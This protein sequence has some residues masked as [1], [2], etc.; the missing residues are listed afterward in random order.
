MPGPKLLRLP[1]VAATAWDPRIRWPVA[2]S[3]TAQTF[4]ARGG[5]DAGA[6]GGVNCL[7]PRIWSPGLLLVALD[8]RWLV[9][10]TAMST[11]TIV[12]T[13]NN[14]RGFVSRSDP[15]ND[16]AMVGPLSPPWSD[17]TT[18]GGARV[19]AATRVV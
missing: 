3:T 15:A 19:W 8:A 4:L 11:T 7:G 2:P 16:V 13:R 17:S 1:P 12:S 9:V 14:R 5:V 6:L 10:K 18:P